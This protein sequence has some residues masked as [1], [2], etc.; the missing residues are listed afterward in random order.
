ML[1]TISCETLCPQRSS[2]VTVNVSVFPDIGI[3]VLL[4]FTV[5]EMQSDIYNVY[6]LNLGRKKNFGDTI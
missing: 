4:T 6:I 2:A 3:S 1:I 5:A